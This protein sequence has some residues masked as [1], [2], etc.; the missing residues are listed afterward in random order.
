MASVSKTN[1]TLVFE[2]TSP[3]GYLFIN[4]N[5]LY[6]LILGSKLPRAKEFKRW[7]TAEVLPSIRQTG[8]YSIKPDADTFLAALAFAKNLMPNLVDVTGC[9]RNSAALQA[10]IQAEARFHVDLNGVKA[11]LP[12]GAPAA[13]LLTPTAI[14]QYFGKSARD[15]N[16]DLH[17]FGFLANDLGQWKLTD[18]GKKFGEVVPFINQLNGYSN[19]RIVWRPAIIDQLQAEYSRIIYM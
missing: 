17:R 6:S 18:K 15:I 19:V 1:E 10:L 12:N 2:V 7:V 13:G 8:K 11:L 3:R 9:S 14:G 4:E 5:G 16:L